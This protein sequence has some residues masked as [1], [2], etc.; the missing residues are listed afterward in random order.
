MNLI[1]KQRLDYET[2]LREAPSSDI[3]AQYARWEASQ[4]QIGAACAICERYLD[5]TADP[6]EGMWLLYAELSPSHSMKLDILARAIKQQP[7]STRLHRCILRCLIL[8]NDASSLPIAEVEHI[9]KN[10]MDNVL[11][12]GS[13][14]HLEALFKA[15]VDTLEQL[16]YSNSIQQYEELVFVLLRAYISIPVAKNALLFAFNTIQRLIGQPKFDKKKLF[17]NA[18]KLFTLVFPTVSFFSEQYSALHNLYLL[19]K[20]MKPHLHPLFFAETLVC[21]SVSITDDPTVKSVYAILFAA[22]AS[23]ETVPSLTV[24]ELCLLLAYDSVLTLQ[25]DDRIFRNTHC[26]IFDVVSPEETLED[27]WIEQLNVIQQIVA[28]DLFLHR[29][30]VI[31][32][33]VRKLMLSK[34]NVYPQSISLSDKQ[35]IQLYSTICHLIQRLPSD[36]RACETVEHLLHVYLPT[37]LSNTQQ[38]LGLIEGLLQT[39]LASPNCTRFTDKIVTIMERVDA[40][41]FEPKTIQLFLKAVASMKLIM[42]QLSDT[43][44][45]RIISCSI[46]HGDTMMTM[47]VL[48]LS[49]ENWS[50][51][52]LFESVVRTIFDNSKAKHAFSATI[53]CLVEITSILIN[54]ANFCNDILR[55]LLIEASDLDG[56]PV[57]DILEYSAIVLLFFLVCMTQQSLKSHIFED[58]GFENVI[59]NILKRVEIIHAGIKM[60]DITLV[61]QYAKLSCLI[62]TVFEYHESITGLEAIAGRIVL[63]CEV[64]LRN[65]E[66]NRLILLYEIVPIDRSDGHGLLTLLSDQSRSIYSITHDL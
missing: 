48:V 55:F 54:S 4:S 18:L 24:S 47:D 29:K 38:S 2:R 44:L 63:E 27:S 65:E 12:H 6:S 40:M 22:R 3:W 49:W 46:L 42:E 16:A 11:K 31:T 51:F 45:T 39:L 30:D 20:F 14:S 37:M 57:K 15:L 60:G 35:I 23:L 26:S 64:A 56:M 43:I 52:I 28:S 10:W 34:S 61:E 8:P 9:F 33:S 1:E 19:C 53:R 58:S 50:C 41:L 66:Q 7:L 21:S 5:S 25:V 62:G 59:E 36:P 13:P 32:N 17:I